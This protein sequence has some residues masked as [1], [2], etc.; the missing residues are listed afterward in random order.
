MPTSNNAE[1]NSNIAKQPD[2]NGIIDAQGF[3]SL[4]AFAD[5]SIDDLQACSGEYLISTIH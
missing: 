4:N 3:L 1:G 5:G 2:E